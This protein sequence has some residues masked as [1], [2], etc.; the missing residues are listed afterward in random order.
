MILDM[1]RLTASLKCFNVIEVALVTLH[2]DLCMVKIYLFLRTEGLAKRFD[3][4]IKFET[5]L[6]S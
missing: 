5:F 4:H 3:L 6:N 2:K 1:E